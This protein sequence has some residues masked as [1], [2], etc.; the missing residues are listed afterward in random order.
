[1]SPT[2][3]SRLLRIGEPLVS[4]NGIHATYEVPVEKRGATSTPLRFTITSPQ[5][6]M[7]AARADAAVVGLLLP[8]MRE[9]LDIEVT[10]S[11]SSELTH[12]LSHGVQRV[13]TTVMPSLTEV[14]VVAPHSEPSLPAAPGVGTGFSAGVDSFATLRDYHFATSV[15]QAYRL[16]HLLFNNVGSHGHGGAGKDVFMRR[17][18]HV[19][20]IADLV[21]LPLITVD[22]NLD[23][24]YE[25][26]DFAQTHTLRNAAV[27]F[28]LQGTLGTF[29]Y[30]SSADFQNVSV[31]ESRYLG[32][33][34]PVLLPMLTV[35]ALDLRPVGSE[36]KRVRKT[37]IVAELPIAW[38]ALDV[39]IAPPEDGKNCSICWKCLRTEV[40]LEIAGVLDRFANV[41]DLDL[42]RQ[43]RSDYIVNVLGG[44]DGHSIEIREFAAERGLDVSRMERLRGAAA[45]AGT[46]GKRLVPSR[47]R[48]ALAHPRW[49][50]R[51]LRDRSDLR[52]QRLRKIHTS[53]PPG[54]S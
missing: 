35:P 36:Y 16:T 40:T 51:R 26:L 28:L 43:A 13:L 34:D 39:C 44:D 49:A 29:L 9:G 48:W 12:H 4:R 42:Y 38:D 31:Q 22:S 8:A 52:S 5:G 11:V 21:G 17:L 20:G 15:P 6:L 10:G 7:L 3:S 37:E 47:L 2:Q 25:S 33:V 1:M 24:F 14:R 53:Q 32:V 54:I 50:W 41:F 30:S 23:D 46:R 19:E 27:A 45:R 18:A